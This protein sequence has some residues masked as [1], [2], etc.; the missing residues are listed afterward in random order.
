[1][2][3]KVQGIF[4]FKW[5]CSAMNGHDYHYSNNLLFCFPSRWSYTS[6]P[7][8]VW[9]TPCHHPNTNLPINILIPCLIGESQQEMYIWKLKILALILFLFRLFCRISSLEASALFWK[10]NYT[11]LILCLNI[12][13]PVKFILPCR[14]VETGCVINNHWW[15][16]LSLKVHLKFYSQASQRE[17]YFSF[18]FS[19][20]ENSTKGKIVK[21]VNSEHNRSKIPMNPDPA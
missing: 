1:M 5:K 8:A 16:T 9:L 12:F 4:T 7:T 10:H 17:I 3:G 20:L 19:L 2:R 13:L 11:P 18:Y 21:N 15:K 6:L 14:I